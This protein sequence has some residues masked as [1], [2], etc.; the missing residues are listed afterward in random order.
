MKAA[1]RRLVSA[2]T[3]TRRRKLITL[4]LVICAIPAVAVFV[5]LVLWTIPIF[6]GRALLAPITRSA[7]GLAYFHDEV[8]QV[9]WSMHVVKIN[10][11]RHDLALDA[12][13]GN[14][15][16]LGMNT[17]SHQVNLLP[18]SLGRPVAAING[19]LYN[20]HP[21]YPGDPEG[22]EIVR[23]ELVSGPSTNRVCFWL[24]A[25]GNPHRDDV[26]SQFKITWPDGTSTPFGPSVFTL[27]HRT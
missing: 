17:V 27:T 13:M 23:G 1:W 26:R 2:S 4:A 5:V 9:P 22:M 14:G 25:A 12:M 18:P 7:R 20:E 19:D 10:R 6:G 15:T 16:T 3:K 11:T 21:D 8:R 24:D